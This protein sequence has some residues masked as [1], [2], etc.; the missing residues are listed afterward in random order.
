MMLKKLN[1][2]S[3]MTPT[4]F[5]LVVVLVMILCPVS[6]LAQEQVN[7]T[8]CE[9]IRDE[10]SGLLDSARAHGEGLEELAEQTNEALNCFGRRIDHEWA[11][12]LLDARAYALDGL[13]RYTEAQE[14]VDQF[15]SSY[16]GQADSLQVARFYMWDLKFKYR[17]EEFEK[18]LESYEQGFPYARALPEE[19]YKHYRLNAGSV[20]LAQGE[21][22]EALNIYRAVYQTFTSIPSPSTPLAEVYGRALVGGAEAQLDLVLYQGEAGIDLDTLIV[23]LS[24]AESI[25]NLAGS[26]ARYASAQ[27]ALALAYA[28]KGN[29]EGARPALDIAF[30]QVRQYDLRKPHL[31]AL[32]RRALIGYRD[33]DYGAALADIDEALTLGQ[34]YAIAEFE[35]R[36]RLLQGQ[37]YEKS[38]R[39]EEAKAA[40]IEAFE[41]SRGSSL[42]RDR[43]LMEIA[44]KGVFRVVEDMPTEPASPFAFLTLGF[45]GVVL[46]MALFGLLGY[47]VWMVPRRRKRQQQ[48]LPPEEGT[49]EEPARTPAARG[50]HGC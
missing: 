9:A 8:P 17:Q 12:W 41:A 4:S 20:Y 28:L 39:L 45:F 46:V 44:S 23:S 3:S 48:T 14:V 50:G 5:C 21:F 33:K 16:I 6:V 19:Q 35:S 27:S 38:D 7:T 37:T 29:M 32:Y 24:Q 11:I 30:N 34:R 47:F 40:Y 2:N 36:L 26:R 22:K 31:E 1:R 18:A 13:Q 49:P 15:F 25:F 43:S 42:E 10:V